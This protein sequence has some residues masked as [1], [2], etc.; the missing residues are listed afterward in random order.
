MNSIL[1][2]FS[3]WGSRNHDYEVRS[4]T[5]HGVE[6]EYSKCPFLKNFEV[7]ELE[8]SVDRQAYESYIKKVDSKMSTGALKESRLNQILKVCY[9]NCK[10]IK[11]LLNT[12]FFT[13]NRIRTT[14][15]VRMVDL[16]KTILFLMIYSKLDKYNKIEIVVELTILLAHGKEWYNRPSFFIS[17]EFK[18][19]EELSWDII[20]FVISLLM[21]SP[22]IPFLYNY[23]NFNLYEDFNE[24]RR[25]CLNK[26]GLFERIAKINLNRFFLEFA[27]NPDD[28][29]PYSKVKKY[30]YFI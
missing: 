2:L 13:I 18:D 22:V 16:Y 30:A 27:E 10:K 15:D 25:Y 7:D 12:D 26:E 19:E 17:S 9:I 28:Q 5:T 21:S 20:I 29:R 4:I 3:C 23:E 11:E 8:M 14:K 1:S 6:K 24:F